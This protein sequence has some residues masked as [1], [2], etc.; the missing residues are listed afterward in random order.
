M[1][2]TFFSVLALL[3]AI[4]AFALAQNDIPPSP[5]VKTSLVIDG[6]TLIKGKPV[7][8]GVTF[9]MPDHWHIYWKNSGDSG[10]PTRYEWTLPDGLSA[11]EILWPTPQRHAMGGLV[12]YGY[13]G[14]ITLPV[15]LMPMRDGVSGEVTVKASWLVCK[16]ICIPESATLSGM[17]TP[18]AEAGRILAQARAQAPSAFDGQAEFRVDGTKLTLS[19]MRSAPWGAV[20]DVTFYPLEDGLI[21]NSAPTTVKTVGNTLSITME[22]GSADVISPWN[23]VLQATTDGNTQAWNISATTLDVTPAAIAAPVDPVSVTP[24]SVGFAVALWLAFL[25]GLILNIMPCV[26]PILALKA[27]ALSKKAQASRAAAAKQGISYTAGVV[28]SFLVIAGGMLALKA[29]GSAIGWGF[30]LQNIGFVAAMLAV[31]LLV[32]ANLLGLFELPVLFGGRAT[33][34]NED[35]LSGSFFTGVLAVMVATPCTAPFMA[36]ALGAT[37]AMPTEQALAVFASLG[38][39]MA[40]PFLL[41]SLWPAARRILPKP[42]AWMNTFKKLLAIPMLATA[43]WLG[44]VLMQLISPTPM[45]LESGHVPYSS[46]LLSELR[47]EGKPVFVDA[48]AAWCLSCKV[49]ER[50][51]L[52]P[53]E[54]VDLFRERGITLMVA[55]WT[56]S[57]PAITEYLA[58]YGRNGVPLYVYYAPHKDGVVLPQILTPGIVREAID[59]AHD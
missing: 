1:R 48:T 55:D 16:D 14:T 31:M 52:K 36:T 21:S 13:G 23:G 24:P 7:W 54:T 10:I 18:D 58:R 47:R 51:A 2:L 25:G 19:V 15:P 33:G 32:S 53:R 38:F 27:L 40:A 11:G 45:K 30:Q 37:L 28:L 41:I 9:T 20:S 49:N 5:I 59:A 26:L 43:I 12:N 4:P 22:R 6:G 8:A 3:I 46:E 29:T 17:L 34:V 56:N 50:V 39:G 57:D 42:G 35:K 44:W